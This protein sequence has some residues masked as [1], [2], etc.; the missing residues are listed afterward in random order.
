MNKAKQE[1]KE[2]KKEKAFKLPK[3]LRLD[4]GVFFF[5]EGTPDSSGVRIS[6]AR[7]IFVGRETKLEQ[8]EERG[9]I[10][11][12]V[13][14]SDIPKDENDN[15]NLTD[16]GKVDSNLPW[17]FDTT[18]I[19]PSKLS[20]ILTAY[21]YGILVEADPD[22]PPQEIKKEEPKN[23]FGYKENGDRVFTGKNSE[24][25]AKL[26]NLT[27]PKLRDFITS[28]PLTNRSRDNL[29]D[30]HSYEVRGY[31][32]LNRP[33]F[34]VLELLKKKLKEFGPSMSS[35]RVNED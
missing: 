17:Y 29:I 27:F 9:E 23:D 33:R 2:E 14:P 11:Y 16:Y 30:M 25:F 35:I 15:K 4:K 28:S 26:Q 21:K 5:D 10:K 34:E 8:Y 6:A 19:D 13:R 20:R 3:Y 22:N 7:K 32:P 18:K 31:N 1:V 24:M 12:K